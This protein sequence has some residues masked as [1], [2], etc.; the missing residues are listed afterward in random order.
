METEESVMVAQPGIKRSTSKGVLTFD[1]EKGLYKSN[2]QKD[3]SLTAQ[4]RQTITTISEYPS[5]RISDSLSGNIFSEEEFGFDSQIFNSVENRVAWIDV[6]EAWTP[7]QVA[8]RL[9]TFPNANLYKI[10]DNKPI[11][12]NEQINAIERKLRTYDKFA[13]AQAIRYPE[14]HATMPGNLIVDRN[15]KIQYRGVYFAPEGKADVDNRKVGDYG[16][17]SEALIAELEA[18]GADATLIPDQSLNG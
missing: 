8:E 17:A 18:Q 9:A 15:G 16:Y 14:D 11:L 12:T 7:A 10:L 1:A 4:I 13:E 5:A 3:K 6:P 2:H